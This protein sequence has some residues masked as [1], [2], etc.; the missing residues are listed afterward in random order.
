MLIRTR[1]AP[2]V[3]LPLALRIV[4]AALARPVQLQT[5]RGTFHA[6]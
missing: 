5:L 1:P 6:F 2:T 4:L 3:V